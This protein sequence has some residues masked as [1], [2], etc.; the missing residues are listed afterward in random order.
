MN[1]LIEFTQILSVVAD[2]YKYQVEELT[3]LRGLIELYI[4]DIC[5]ILNH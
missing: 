5:I 1:G 2:N 4:E 3:L